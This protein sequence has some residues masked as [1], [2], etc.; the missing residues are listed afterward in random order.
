MIVHK[1]D[2]CGEVRDCSQKEIDRTEYDICAECWNALMAKLKDKGRPKT[3]RE[4]VIVPPATIRDTPPETQPPFPGKP[5]DII[6]G[7][8]QTNEKRAN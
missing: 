3:R 7:P 1:C 6:A 8:Q 5:P 2:L 4:T